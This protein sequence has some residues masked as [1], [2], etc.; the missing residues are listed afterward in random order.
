MIKV[1]LKAPILSKSGYGEH[2]RFIY[3]ALKEDP[4]N[5]DVY[6]YPTEWGK[7][8]WILNETNEINQINLDVK[9]TTELLNSGIPNSVEKPLFDV[10]LQNTIPNEFEFSARTNIGVTAGIETDRVTSE[11]IQKTNEMQGLMV[12]SQ[13]AKNGFTKTKYDGTRGKEKFVLETKTPIDVVGYP[14]KTHDSINLEDSLNLTTKFNFLSIC[15][16]GPRKNV[17]TTLIAFLEEFKNDENVGLVLKTHRINNSLS[18]RE[19]LK[20][21]VYQILNQYPKRKCKVYY[22]HGNMT[23]QELHGLYTHP[24]I[25]AYVTTT[26][27][28]GYGLPIFEA[29]YSAMPVIAPSWSGHV[30]FLY[31]PRNTGSKKVKREA[32]FEKVKYNLAPVHESAVWDTVIN[33]DAQWCYVDGKS[34]QK[35]MRKMKSEYIAKKR[36]AEKLQKHLAKTNAP[37]KMYEKVQQSVIRFHNSNLQ[38]IVK[39]LETGVTSHVCASLATSSVR[40]NS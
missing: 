16:W 10:S 13:H 21:E 14:V 7:S 20:P 8:S 18:D 17:A 19:S 40:K 5:F 28:E 39:N 35:A 33:A 3:R 31:M 26:H 34:V 36:R 25:H 23:E 11:W 2:A 32:M 15:Q 4:A 1:L 29:A 6:V 24:K 38:Q 12:V 27:G 37:E 22:L 9:R 30:D